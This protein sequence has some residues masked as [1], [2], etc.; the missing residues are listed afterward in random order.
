MTLQG[1]CHCGAVRFEAAHTPTELRDC[2]C[3]LC[4]RLG[5]RWAYYKLIDV[6]FSGVTEAYIQGD[7]TLATH[8]CVTCGCVMYWLPLP[9]P[10]DKEPYDRMGVNTR[11]CEPA[12]LTG[13]RVRLLDGADT[14]T[15]LD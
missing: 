8:R 10:D 5:V 14:W 6:T 9:A 11:L 7:K 4:R 15:L 3:S 12:A 1:S 2:N 13:I